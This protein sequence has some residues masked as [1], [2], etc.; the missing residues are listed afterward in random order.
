MIITHRSRSVLS[1][2]E[3]RVGLVAMF[4]DCTYVLRLFMLGVEAGRA[5]HMCSVCVCVKFSVF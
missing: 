4:A 1:A 5:A 2:S 3:Q